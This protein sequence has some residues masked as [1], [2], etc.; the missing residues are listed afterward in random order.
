[1]TFDWKFYATMFAAIAGIAV[2]IFIWQ[3]DLSAHSLSVRLASSVALQSTGTTSI[4]DIQ[5]L[6]D[7][8][9]VKT[10]FLST[11]ELLNDGSKPISVS[12]FES[13]IELNVD[14]NTQIVRA[15]VISIEPNNL[16]VELDTNKQSVKLLPLLL[17][18]NDTITI[19]VITSGSPPN[20][21]AQARI[22]GISKINFEDTVTKK[23]SWKAVAKNAVL[24]FMGIVLYWIYGAAVIRPTEV[25]F[26]RTM[27]A[28]TMLAC[29]ILSI[30][31]ARKSYE[32]AGMDF[33]KADI[34]IVTILPIL[35]GVPITLY[36]LNRA[37][38]KMSSYGS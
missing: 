19:A 5:I 10:P 4:P 23:E 11:L 21:I 36:T 22:A 30:W 8:V 17:N 31:A 1:M 6:I 9:N 28:I 34:W 3:V 37:R 24:S 13:P 32:A 12:D 29:V 18:P 26:G 27:S 25:R 33:N 14:Q 7:G 20:F 15:R 16:K 38:R 2:P 35:L